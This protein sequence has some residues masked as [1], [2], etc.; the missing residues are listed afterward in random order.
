MHCQACGY[1]LWNLAAR[2][3]PECG[4]PFLP[5]DFEFVPGTVQ[6]CCPHCRHPRHGMDDRGHLSPRSFNCE[7]CD[8]A[9]DMD[10]MVLLPAEGLA[11]ADTEP[12]VMPWLERRHR[13]VIKG[14]FGTVGL[15][16]VLP[17]R[18]MRGVP[19]NA[20]VGEALAF[21]MA[22]AALGFLGGI[23]LPTV[24]YWA[25]SY[26]V[27]GWG[28]D[29]WDVLVLAWWLLISFF[30][31]VGMIPVWALATHL[32][33]R[34][35]GGSRFSVDRTMQ[36]LGYSAGA[37]VL[38]AIPFVGA[39]LGWLW[40]S[41]SAVLMVSSG[42]KVHAGRVVLAVYSMPVALALVAG[43]MIGFSMWWI[44][45]SMMMGGAWVTSYS[46]DAVHDGVLANTFMNEGV[47]PAHALE[48]IPAGNF[49]TYAYDGPVGRMFCYEY[50]GTTMDDVPVADGNLRTFSALGTDEQR[51]II[52]SLV[53]D[54]PDGVIAHR[55]GDYVFTY[56]GA[57]LIGHNPEFWVVVMI[58]DP[59]VNG[60]P[61]PDDTVL[62][63]VDDTGEPMWP[64]TYEDLA[65][66]LLEQNRYRATIGLAP[67]P[68]L[69]TVTNDSPATSP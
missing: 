44:N 32:V 7:Q 65:S 48:F 21:G 61:L 66:E 11:D 56:H 12:G 49:S 23:A 28:P 39:P 55:V 8:A 19:K 34:L 24:A 16:M 51:E 64:I 58:P 54:W 52:A 30:I 18:L 33:L 2:E 22:T 13:G 38:C 36:A 37:T 41:I 5:G 67:L 35:T 57:S 9:I 43:G 60:V 53:D 26:F 3:C 14:F 45:T 27:W 31:V 50:S 69:L 40:W 1:S 4:A 47:S 20:S 46:A 15:A 68:D 29:A 10:A 42:Q 25:W 6:F 59:D 62:I 63:G 17:A